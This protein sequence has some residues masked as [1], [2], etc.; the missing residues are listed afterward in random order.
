M[1]S[2]QDIRR[3]VREAL[4]NEAPPGGMFGNFEVLKKRKQNSGSGS[5][6]DSNKKV[7][8][9][10]EHP[11]FD[12][13]NSLSSRT[14]KEVVDLETKKIKAKILQSYNGAEREAFEEKLDFFLKE[15][16]EL[17]YEGFD[18]VISKGGVVNSNTIIKL[19]DLSKKAKK[20]LERKHPSSVNDNEI[21]SWLQLQ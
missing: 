16:S 4:L 18:D 13:S 7:N 11:A 20:Y 14:N 17:M 9:W 6:I 10:H 8:S 15:F 12:K 5:K 19:K 3:I 2:K 1:N 21:Q